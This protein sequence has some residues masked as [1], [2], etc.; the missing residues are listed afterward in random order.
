MLVSRRELI[1]KELAQ[2]T[3]ATIAVG[4]LD[5]GLSYAGIWV[6]A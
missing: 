1:A 4:F 6:M 3:G 2:G 5:G